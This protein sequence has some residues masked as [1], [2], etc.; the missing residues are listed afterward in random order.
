MIFVLSWTTIATSEIRKTLSQTIFVFRQVEDQWSWRQLKVQSEANNFR[1]GA[2]KALANIVMAL[3]EC[4]TRT[5]CKWKI[6]HSAKLSTTKN[7]VTV[8]VRWD[9]FCKVHAIISTNLIFWY[10][11]FGIIIFWYYDYY[12]YHYQWDPLDDLVGFL[13]TPSGLFLEFLKKS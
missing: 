7:K 11:D 9:N 8:N 12:Y 1:E 4:S 6:K 2:A 3:L 10:Y 5:L 13:N